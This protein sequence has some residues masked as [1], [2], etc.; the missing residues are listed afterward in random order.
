M[1]ASEATLSSMQLVLWERRLADEVD[2]R[3]DRDILGIRVPSYGIPCMM[4]S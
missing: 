1:N 4:V 2:C 3:Y